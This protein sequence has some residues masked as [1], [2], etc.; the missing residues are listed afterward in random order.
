MLGGGGVWLNGTVDPDLGLVYFATGNPVPMFGGRDP[1]GRQSVHRLGAR[2]RH[3]DRRAA[4]ALPG[5]PARRLGCGHRH[6]GT[7]LRGGG[8]RAAAQGAGGH[9]GRRLSLPV[10]PGDGRAAPADRRAAGAPGRVP[11]HGADP[12]VPGRGREH[13]ARLLLLARQGAAAVRAQL[14]QLHPALGGPPHRRGARRADSAGAGDADVVQPADRLHLC[15][16][17]RARRARPAVRGSLA[18]PPERRSHQPP[19]GGRHH[20]GRRPADQPGRL[21][22]GGP[23]CAA[24]HERSAHDRGRSDVP[25][26]AR[27]SGRGLR[28]TDRRAGVGVPDGRRRRPDAPGAGGRL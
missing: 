12:T 9:P 25:R 28:R 21:E 8:R 10:R 23:Q 17:P 19:G 16:G 5:G 27:R 13:P 24:R 14:Q 2:A 20:L 15:A 1:R 26:L 6:A 7:A 22:A 18:V 3:G 4:L 11:A